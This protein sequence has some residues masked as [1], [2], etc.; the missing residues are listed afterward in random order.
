MNKD[1]FTG[2]TALQFLQNLLGMNENTHFVATPQ[3]NPT[4]A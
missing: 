1:S 4:D 2:F 3:N